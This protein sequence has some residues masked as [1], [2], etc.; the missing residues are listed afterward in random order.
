MEMDPAD[1]KAPDSGSRILPLRTTLRIYR[2][3]RGQVVLFAVDRSKS[4]ARSAR[5]AAPDS[6]QSFWPDIDRST[7]CGLPQT[8]CQGVLQ[9]CCA[10]LSHKQPLTSLI[11]AVTP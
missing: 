8:L 4:R 1:S 3:N 2:K 11:D 9:P 5:G 10:L 6:L 7:L